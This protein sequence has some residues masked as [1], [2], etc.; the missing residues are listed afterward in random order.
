LALPSSALRDD[1]LAAPFLTMLDSGPDPAAIVKDH[2]QIVFAN[3]KLRR[4]CGCVGELATMAGTGWC[5]IRRR[6]N[7]SPSMG[8]I[9][10]SR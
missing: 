9:S 10:I 2:R 7:V 1:L 3:N 5:P 4:Y 6:R 8:G